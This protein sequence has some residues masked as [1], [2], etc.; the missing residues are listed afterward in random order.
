MLLDFY[1]D[2]YI[3]PFPSCPVYNF[4]LIASKD[5]L[6]FAVQR[7]DKIGEILEAQWPIRNFSSSFK[8]EFMG[9]GTEMV[10]AKIEMN[11]RKTALKQ[12]KYLVMGG[13]GEGK[14]GMTGVCLRVAG[15]EI[16]KHREVGTGGD[17][18]LNLRYVESRGAKR[19]LVSTVMQATE[20]YSG[21]VEKRVSR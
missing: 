19:H 11:L 14:V 17:E 20:Q 8:L 5:T 1:L 4:Q 21:K 16:A 10:T 9:S 15:R 18:E 13:Q 12:I 7:L 2:L 6:I 3:P